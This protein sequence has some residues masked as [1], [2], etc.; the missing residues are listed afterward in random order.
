R[1]PRADRRTDRRAPAAAGSGAGSGPGSTGHL[2]RPLHDRTAL[3]GACPNAGTGPRTA[4]RAAD[5]RLRTGTQPERA[6]GVAPGEAGLSDVV[7]QWRTL[8]SAPAPASPGSAYL[9]RALSG[10]RAAGTLER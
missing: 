10:R 8:H 3:P 1:R 7:C 9:Q 5:Q 2:V 4:A 6:T